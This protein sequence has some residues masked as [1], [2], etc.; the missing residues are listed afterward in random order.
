MFARDDI[1][2][3][4]LAYLQEGLTARGAGASLTTACRRKFSPVFTV[5]PDLSTSILTD[6]E[7][8][9]PLE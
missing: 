1:T 8:G 2:A 3:L 7:A 6:R 5:R 4:A 9:L